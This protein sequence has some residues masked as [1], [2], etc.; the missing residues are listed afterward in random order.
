MS[1]VVGDSCDDCDVWDL[2]VGEFD[3]SQVLMGDVAT[4][5]TQVNVSF[6]SLITCFDFLL[7]IF[8]ESCSGNSSKN[9]TDINYSASSPSF[10]PPL[11]TKSVTFPYL[12]LGARS[13][14]ALSSSPFSLDDSHL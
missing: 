1:G 5:R 4:G 11:T 10:F 9:L 6:L 13:A 12:F 7:I 14:L 8:G 3:Y 2:G